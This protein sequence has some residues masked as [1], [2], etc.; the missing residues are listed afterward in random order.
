MELDYKKIASEVVNKHPE[1]L[2]IE[3]AYFLS[4]LE[5]K[6]PLIS[7]YETTEDYKSALDGYDL[8]F[9]GKFEK[10][11]KVILETYKIYLVNVPGQGYYLP[12]P[13]KQIKIGLSKTKNGVKS[14]IKKG[15]KI[16][17]HVD[18]RRVDLREKN[19]ALA[20][21]AAWGMIQ[22]LLK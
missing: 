18:Y 22:S 21:Q 17:T 19:A 2:I 15:N 9:V 13:V 12:D 5:M 8:E 6:T 3:K 11:R 4:L 7:E 1:N 20:K 16:I 10:L 14:K